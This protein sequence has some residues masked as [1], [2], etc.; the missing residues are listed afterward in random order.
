MFFDLTTPI[1][2]MFTVVKL[3]CI[4]VVLFARKERYFMSLLFK[5]KRIFHIFQSTTRK[6]QILYSFFNVTRLLLGI[7]RNMVK[8]GNTQRALNNVRGTW[9]FSI[10]K[11]SYFS[12]FYISIYI[13]MT[14]VKIAFILSYSLFILSII[15]GLN[16]HPK[17]VFF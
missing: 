17:I 6:I 8:I 1:A 15:I 7:Y 13:P 4:A 14:Y 11:S 9:F 2:K 5:I 10:S 3:F 12:I 16:K